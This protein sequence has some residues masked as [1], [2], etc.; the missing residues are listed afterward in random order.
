M[1]NIYL[2]LIFNL[3]FLQLILGGNTESTGR[4]I[5]N[6]GQWDN[7][8][9]YR[10]DFK[11]GYLLLE[12][13][14]FTYTFFNLSEFSGEEG[15]HHHGDIQIP[16]HTYQVLFQNSNPA[17]QVFPE[18][19]HP[20]YNNY[21][22]G[23]DPSRWAEKVKIHR[24]VIYRDIYKGINLIVEV[25]NDQLKYTF[26]VSPMANPSQISL[27]YLG[28]NGISTNSQGE[29][30]VQ[31]SFSTVRE[32]KPFT[33]EMSASG[34]RKTVRSEYL[35]SGEV[36]S[37]G[38]PDG[39]DRNQRLVIDPTVIFSTYT[40]SF[41]DN[42]GFTATYDNSGNAYGGGII[43]NATQG[44]TGY[45]VLGAYQT[46]YGGGERDA[47]IT[48]FNTVGNALIFSTYLGGLYA[49][50]PHSL[51]VDANDNLFVMGRTS[52]PNFPTTASAYDPTNDILIDLFVS[53][54]SANGT[55]LASTYLG[56]SGDDGVCGDTVESFL[57]LPLEY[58]YGDDSRGEINVDNL[59]NIYVASCT[60]SFDFPMVNPLQ[61]AYGGGLM[62]AVVF[63]M[64]NTL[65]SLLFS[66]YL[67]GNAADAAYGINVDD[68]YITYVTGGTASSAF[69]TTP[70]T[71]A[72]SYQGGIADGFLVKI[73]A[74]GG[75]MLAGTFIGT[76]GYDQTYSVQ[77][78]NNNEVYVVGQSTGSFPV[79]GPVYSNP[80]SRQ[81]IAKFDNNLTTILRSTTFG[82]TGSASPNISPT[83][84]LVD[85]CG[86]IYVAGWGG[87][88]FGYNA[89]SSQ[90]FGLPTTANAFQANTDGQDFYVI[91]LSKNMQTLVYS[92]F[93]GG[94]GVSEH[95]DGGTSRFDP[96][97]IM[98][99]AVC[100]GCGGS[101]NFPTT[102]GVWSNTNNSFN[103][104]LG[105][106]KIDLE[107]SGMDANFEPTDSTGTVIN[108]I[109]EG[110]APLLVNFDNQ[111]TGNNPATTSYLWDFGV[112]G[113]IS[114]AFEPSYTYLVPGTYQVML[115]ITDTTSCNPT[116][117]AYKTI[118]VYGPPAVDAGPTQYMCPGGLGVE[119]SS[120]GSG[121]VAWTPALYL[122]D[123]TINNP[124][125]TPP[126]T[127]L[128]TV[129]VID[130][131][132]CVA[133]D[134]VSVVH[135]NYMI[136]NA[137]NDSTVCSGG[138]IQMNATSN[139]ISPVYT[140]VPP[141][142]LSNPNISNPVYNFPGNQTYVVSV[143]DSL[144]CFDTD[145]VSVSVFQLTVNQNTS[146]VCQGGV[147]TLQL[148]ISNAQTYSWSPGTYLSSTS[149][150]N[151]TV[152]NPQQSI[153]YQVFVTSVEGCQD[154]STYQ[155]NVFPLPTAVAGNDQSTCSGNTLQLNGSGAVQYQWS[156]PTG[157]S[158]PFISNPIVN[159]S[160]STEYVL[161][162][163]DVNNCSDTDTLNVTIFPLPVITTG[164][165]YSIC[166]D[167]TVMIQA[168]GGESY[169][170]SQS[171]TLS[172]FFVSNPLAFPDETTM[173]YVVGTDM[174]GCTGDASATV[175]VTPTPVTQIFGESDLCLGQTVKLN[176]SGGNTYSWSTGETTPN[177][178]LIPSSDFW[179]YCQTFAGNCPG[180][181]DSIFVTVN[182]DF[183]T[184]EFFA[185][186][187]TGWAPMVVQFT[188]LSTNADY[189]Q[190]DFGLGNGKRSS[191]LNPQ[192]VYPFAGDFTVTLI[193]YTEKGCYDT[194]RHNIFAENVTLFAPSVFTPNGDGF[195]DEFLVGYYGIKNLHIDIYSRW[196]MLIYSS[197][198]KDFRWNGR[199]KD[200][201]CPEGVYVFV[202][203]GIGENNKEY[204]RKGT[205]TLIR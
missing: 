116:D 114:T 93:F 132:G 200:A 41:Q 182:Q 169:Q 7:R 165:P 129:T 131:N 199:Y 204:I 113:G 178:S 158:N 3:L 174:N 6:K 28:T 141:V 9:M 146:S 161:T 42:W 60:K 98:Y 68:N 150:Y 67:G 11:G 184:A 170:W 144:G 192:E 10:Q 127:A 74:S 30:Q 135:N 145:T 31:T 138:A 96:S 162:V 104:N 49:D 166:S 153:T 51:V 136:L 148:N 65:S 202:A 53:K 139:G 118:V 177:I 191:E 86:N 48:K 179:V 14:R 64:D 63:K 203:T 112:P 171:P 46:A 33:Y 17:V 43:W 54:F 188:N 20:D 34:I 94:N 24:R 185:D 38:L 55:L 72:A 155:L 62:D 154:S 15:H 18:G 75:T 82:V 25:I 92:T 164:S 123:S 29:L 50:Q 40:G 81:F 103:C 47:T 32:L 2:F 201:D 193:A 79:T 159:L 36:M 66:T 168:F 111:C 19:Q 115:V 91:V 189:F 39:Y 57:N 105:L 180:Y 102:A 137:G 90:T 119:L 16:T 45:P 87:T 8:I 122:N 77:I 56:G 108:V 151:P 143:I 124:I 44:S 109:T 37:F 128:F 21:Y 101:S 149:V 83:A 181:P 35:L 88:L 13:D 70:G 196:G 80:N 97:G 157:L 160:A 23:D 120:I 126:N 4:F 147:I 183:P 1:K 195:D 173:Y 22:M 89:N 69:P 186:P 61:G 133:S 190:W 172:S 100:A 99:E 106:F 134:T 71:Y 167:D 26:E 197:D 78:E 5:E 152:T 107:L 130:S 117:T 52:S 27:K 121:A 194:V 125:A 163:T 84:F 198:D 110:C 73:D 85:N 187:D 142:G 95:V 205:V 12:K 156:P 59:G 175:N 176:A 140:W 58:N 76:S